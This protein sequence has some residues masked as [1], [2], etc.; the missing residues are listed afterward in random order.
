MHAEAKTEP[1]SDS[2]HGRLALKFV[3]DGDGTRLATSEAQTPLAIQRP[4]YPEGPAV[5]HTL[6]LHP[7]GGLVGGDRLDMQF[8]L[9]RGAHALLS[10]PAAG[11]CYRSG[12]ERAA[13]LT[14]VAEVDDGAYLEWLP[15]ETIVF[16][17]ARVRQSLRVELDAGGA[18]LGWDVTRFGRSAR[19][20]RFSYGEWRAD[21]EIWRQGVPLWV[22]RQRLAGGS[23][24]LDTPFGLAGQPVVGS[25]VYVGQAV[26]PAV[27]DLA[28]ASWHAEARLGEAGVTRLPQGLLCRYRGPASAEARAWFISVWDVVRRACIG[29]AACAPRIWRT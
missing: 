15:Q 18:F 13:Q 14:I 17:G 11:K 5:C 21:T 24:V 26:A 28:R 7:P 16:N 8:V 20:E 4:F 12:G 27:I 2:W 3:R 22:D 6:V 25:L 9:Q 29:R 1:P 19:G 10:T 23:S